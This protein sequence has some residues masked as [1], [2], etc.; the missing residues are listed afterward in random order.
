MPC[1]PPLA[2]QREFQIVLLGRQVDARTVAVEVA[3]VLMLAIFC[4]R[5]GECGDECGRFVALLLLIIVAAVA[6]IIAGG[7]DR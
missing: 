3:V 1:S 6:L 7:P 5:G 4:W 2:G